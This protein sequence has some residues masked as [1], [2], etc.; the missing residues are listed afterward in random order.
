[1]AD[2]RQELHIVD[3]TT[4]EDKVVLS[5]PIEEQYNR[6][7]SVSWNR[8]NNLILFSSMNSASANE[9]HDMFTLDPDSGNVNML[10]DHRGKDYFLSTPVVSRDGTRIAAVYCK[11]G[12][13]KKSE[14]LF[15]LRT[16][17][18]GLEPLTATADQFCGRPNWSDDGKHLYYAA[19]TN[20]GGQRDLYRVPLDGGPLEQLTSGDE[21]DL[22]PDV[23]PPR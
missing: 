15:T 18:T 17:G 13:T 12:P 10:T 5:G 6:H 3:V 22:D 11:R 14:P 8:T 9:Y 23:S 2:N 21:D 4:E 20:S 16:D 1:M 7:L 19:S